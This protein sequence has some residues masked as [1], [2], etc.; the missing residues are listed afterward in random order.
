MRIVQ[1]W[2]YHFGQLKDVKLAGMCTVYRECTSY[3]LVRRH[4]NVSVFCSGTR[5]VGSREDGEMCIG[6]PFEMYAKTV[7]GIM[8]TVGVMERLSL[9]TA[10]KDALESCGTDVPDTVTA[11]NCYVGAYVLPAR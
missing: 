8:N 5:C 1:G 3:P 11:A 6:I 4:P 10:V 7:D 2:A 9:K